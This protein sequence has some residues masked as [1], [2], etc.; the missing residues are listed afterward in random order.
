MLGVGLA[1]LAAY[2][3]KES[4]AARD[5]ARVKRLATQRARLLGLAG[6]EPGP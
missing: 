4:L 5:R 2:V 3:G 1:A 6:A